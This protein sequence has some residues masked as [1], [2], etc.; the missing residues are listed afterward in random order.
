M[1]QQDAKQR[2]RHDGYVFLQQFLGETDVAEIRE[3]M[4]RFIQDVLPSLP[5]EQVYYEDPGD[6]IT[7]K[8]IQQLGKHDS[9]FGHWQNNSA[10]RELAELLLEGAVIPT[11]MQYFNK[12]PGIGKATPPHQDGFY[13]MLDPC[14]AVTLWLALE[15]V[16]EENGC[17][18]Y[19]RGSHC[20]GMRPHRRTETLG[21]SQGIADFPTGDDMAKEVAFPAQ[22]GDLLA[23]H[24]LTIHRADQN[25]SQSRTRQ[26]IGLIYYSERAQENAATAEAYQKKLAKCLTATGKVIRKA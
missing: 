17:V 8:Q 16:D 19:I 20:E 18:R 3:N 5:V 12:P 23:H 15:K 1:N 6:P 11:N 25:C 4:T 22:A 24:A 10:F 7:L 21:F 13:F 9:Y 14:E 2:F 26:A